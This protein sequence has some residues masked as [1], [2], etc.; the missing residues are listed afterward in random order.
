QE[1]HSLHTYGF[2]LGIFEQAVRSWAH[3]Q[4]P[5]ADL[6]GPNFPMLGDHFSPILALLAPVYRLFPTA[7]PLLVAQ[8]VLLAV[9]A[10]PIVRL[11]QRFRQARDA[12]VIGLGYG[13][14]WGIA[15][16][17][18]FDFHEYAFA[19]P[20]LAFS[21]CALVEGR[22]RAAVWWAL[23]LLLVKED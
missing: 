4:L 20:L 9:L 16:A 17:V 19:V 18:E 15:Q 7:S 3:G 6:K 13:M 22:T 5:V 11:A 1:H 23:P 2:D 10:V 12:L 14:S 21:A 8:A